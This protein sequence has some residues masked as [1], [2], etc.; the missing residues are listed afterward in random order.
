MSKINE[1]EAGTGDSSGGGNTTA[2]ID[3]P[4]VPFGSMRRRKIKTFKEFIKE[5]KH[6]AD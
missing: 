6:G 3:I 4:E 1:N 5:K 2:G